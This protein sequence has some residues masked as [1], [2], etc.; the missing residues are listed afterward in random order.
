M[1]IKKF[2]KDASQILG[3]DFL[4]EEISKKDALKKF[5][6]DIKNKKALLK[7]K[8]ESKKLKT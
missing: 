7:K 1:K 3:I 5:V 6:I 2:L 4:D 8:L